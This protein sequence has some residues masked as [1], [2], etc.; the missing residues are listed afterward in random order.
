MN[1]EVLTVW[2]FDLPNSLLDADERDYLSGLPEHLPP[3]EWLW[4][5]MDRIWHAQG[6]D[7]RISLG[8]Q[9]LQRYYRHPVW[10]ANGVFTA[11]DPASVGHR[12]A[13]AQYVQASGHV[14]VADYGGGF[15][16]LARAIAATSEA[17]R[18]SVIEPHVTPVARGLS[19]GNPRIN[20]VPFLEAEQYDLIIAQDILE[21]LAAPTA[22]VDLFARSVKPGG[23][24]IIANCFFPVIQC[25]LPA[26]FHLRHTFRFIVHSLGLRYAGSVAG[27]EHA[28]IFIRDGDQ[29]INVDRLR[30]FERLSHAIGPVINRTYEMAEKLKRVMGR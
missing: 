15:G 1:S 22:T 5:E 27:A 14:E 25:H 3:I 24:V 6:L 23:Q 28:K 13:I 7:N 20:F 19:A 17:V 21:H 29:V 18:V 26:T 10:I 4:S 16:E 8:E 2:G 9:E 30:I 11:M 12:K